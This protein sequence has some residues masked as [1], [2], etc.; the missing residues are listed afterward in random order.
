VDVPI[1]PQKTVRGPEQD[2]LHLRFEKSD[3]TVPQHQEELEWLRAGKIDAFFAHGALVIELVQKGLAKILIDIAKTDL[4]NRNNI[5][6][7]VITVHKEFALQN[8][9]LVILYLRQVLRAAAWAKTHLDEV[10]E[11]AAKGQYGTTPEQVRLSR[12]EGFHLQYTPGFAPEAV[13]LLKEQKE[14]LLRKGFIENDFSVDDWLAPSYLEEARTL[15]P[16]EA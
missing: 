7:S 5:Y 16:A 9:D 6:P 12:N 2:N 15:A 4:N 13:Q 10:L 8:R 11:I 3:Q 14:F 1:N